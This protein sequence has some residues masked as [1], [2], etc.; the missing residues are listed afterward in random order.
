MGYVTDGI[1]R[2]K[3]YNQAIKYQTLVINEGLNNDILEEQ[4]KFS[5]NKTSV[6]RYQFF[7]F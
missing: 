4:F 6:Y 3:N 2:S 1:V 7:K 5:D